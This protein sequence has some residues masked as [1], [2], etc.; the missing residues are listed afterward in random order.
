LTCSQGT[1]SSSWRAWARANAACSS[2]TA[3][4]QPSLQTSGSLAAVI[5]LIVFGGVIAPVVLFSGFG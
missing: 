3:T 4:G 1:L 2:S 5:A